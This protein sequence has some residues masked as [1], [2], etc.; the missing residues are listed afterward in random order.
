[1]LII[2][3]VFFSTFFEG[4]LWASKDGTQE[5]LLFVYPCP[6]GYCRCELSSA[7]SLD[8]MC[9]R[10]FNHNDPDDQCACG[11]QGGVV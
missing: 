8:V 9:V 7:E 2:T 3:L 1:M 10:Q 5:D 11:R 6:A 4:N